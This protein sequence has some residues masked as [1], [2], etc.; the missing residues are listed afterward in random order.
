MYECLKRFRADG[1]V[2]DLGEIAEFKKETAMQLL[3]MGRIKIIDEKPAEQPE[4]RV[5]TP[6][7]R[8]KK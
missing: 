7:S 2:Y 8:R 3:A 1:Q 6:R 5:V 4:K